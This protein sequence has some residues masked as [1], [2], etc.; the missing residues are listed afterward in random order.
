MPWVLS[1]EMAARMKIEEE[2]NLF[3]EYFMGRISCEEYCER[4]DKL[5]LRYGRSDSK[6]QQEHQQTKTN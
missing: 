4:K 3:K 2:Y 1:E 5:E 6:G